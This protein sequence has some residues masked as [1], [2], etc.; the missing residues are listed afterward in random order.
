MPRD[1][2]ARY[3]RARVVVQA[4]SALPNGRICGPR[5]SSGCI[6]FPSPVPLR[7]RA[8]RTPNRPHAPRRQPSF[9]PFGVPSA[10]NRPNRLIPRPR[11]PAFD[12]RCARRCERPA[13]GPV[14]PGSHRRWDAY[15]V[16]DMGSAR[17]DDARVL[18]PALRRMADWRG[19]F[20]TGIVDQVGPDRVAVFIDWQNTYHCFRD[21]FH[22]PGDPGRCGNVR[23]KAFA[24]L[25][26]SKGGPSRI[27][28]QIAIY[29]GEPDPRRDKRTHA[30][31]LRQ[32]H[33]WEQECG[34]LLRVRSRALRYPPGRPPSEA[35]EKGIDVQLAIDA[36]TMAIAGEYD[37][38][39]LVTTDTDLLPVV[40][41]LLGLQRTERPTG[42]RGG[43]IQRAVP[44]ALGQ[45]RHRSMD[46]PAGLRR[47]PRSYRLQPLGSRS[48][49]KPFALGACHQPGR[50]PHPSF[51]VPCATA[52]P[53]APGPTPADARRLSPPAGP[54]RRPAR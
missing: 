27:V 38:A 16:L 13:A 3:P 49:S 44:R 33:R 1:A 32:R 35:Q 29:R 19:F 31:H 10:P 9:R 24:E 18:I 50:P 21:A 5:R 39:V 47:H 7:G 15:R 34:A 11:L 25:L 40:E 51:G 48:P 4:R 45:R 6:P 2:A 54:G 14:R 46:R 36:M 26:A 52:G 43:R 23:P 12:V 28:S 42:R 17:S 30:A 20:I 8:L 41:G 53:V 37:V 22:R